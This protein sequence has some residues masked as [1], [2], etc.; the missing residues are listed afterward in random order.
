MVKAF[1]SA[2]HQ[3]V[4]AGPSLYER[5]GFG[6]ESAVVKIVRRILPSA[7]TELAEILYNVPAFLRSWRTQRNLAPDFIYERYNLYHLAG[8][9]L[10]R[11]CGVP[12]CLEVNSPLAE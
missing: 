9:M 1:R 3:V 7:V 6:G 2:G 12:L 11:W 8:A 5:A 4:V 10:A